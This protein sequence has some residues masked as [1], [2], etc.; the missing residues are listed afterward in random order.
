MNE[1]ITNNSTQ[2]HIILMHLGNLWNSL[3]F[4]LQ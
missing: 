1:I 4:I 2:S 3:K